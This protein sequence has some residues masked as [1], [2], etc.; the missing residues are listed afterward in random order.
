MSETTTE[1]TTSTSTASIFARLE[2][3]EGIVGAVAPVAEGVVTAVDPAAAPLMARVS[4]LEQFAVSLLSS[5]DSAFGPGKLALPA[6]PT[7]ATPIT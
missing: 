3:L 4:Q 5:L 7:P 2:Q 6:A 1:A